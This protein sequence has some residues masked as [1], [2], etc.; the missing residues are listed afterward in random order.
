MG[1]RCSSA[2]TQVCHRNYII[3]A[4]VSYTG[5]D[6]GFCVRGMKVGKGSGDCLQ[7]VQGRTLVGG[8]LAPRK[9]LIFEYLGSFSV[10]NFEA[11]CECDEVY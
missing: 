10:N 1:P 2:E 8:P 5:A 6:L 7:W 3:A 11:F 4:R 9:L